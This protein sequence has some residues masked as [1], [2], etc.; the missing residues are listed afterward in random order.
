[1]QPMQSRTRN[2][3]QRLVVL[4]VTLLVPGACSRGENGLPLVAPFNSE[5]RIGTVRA[6]WSVTARERA[7]AD[8][9]RLAEREREVQYRVDVESRLEDKV[10]VRLATFR[11]LDEKGIVVA[12]SPLSVECTLG[13]GRTRGVMTNSVWVPAGSV[14]RIARFG[15]HSLAVPLGERGRAIYREW[16]LQSRPGSEREVDAEL[17]RQAAAP[18]CPGEHG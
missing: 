13:S 7:F 8:G 16:L 2:G 10:Y 1:M 6:V 14:E 12:E 11:L 9:V 15:I 18:P 5:T 17:A 3:G 4:L